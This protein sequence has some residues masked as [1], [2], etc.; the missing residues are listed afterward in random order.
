MCGKWYHQTEQKPSC[1]FD[2]KGRYGTHRGH[3][4]HV[5]SCFVSQRTLA[6]HFVPLIFNDESSFVH[7]DTFLHQISC[8]FFAGSFSPYQV[9]VSRPEL[10]ILIFP[11]AV[12]TGRAPKRSTPSTVD[13]IIAPGTIRNL[14][15]IP[16]AKNDSVPNGYLRAQ[17]I[18]QN[19]P[20]ASTVSR[21]L[22]KLAGGVSEADPYA[23]DASFSRSQLCEKELRYAQ[24]ALPL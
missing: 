19:Q 17:I 6:G 18:R 20:E 7:E 4:G 16:S 1:G 12:Q 8:V 2:A 11:T 21:Q 23:P 15:K 24:S 14:C 5:I 10:S 13:C 9:Y 22:L 3:L